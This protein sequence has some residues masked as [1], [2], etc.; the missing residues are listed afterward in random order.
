MTPEQ[1]VAEGITALQSPVVFE[2]VEEQPEYV[3]DLD[4]EVIAA[5]KKKGTL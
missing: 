1:A 2:L 5:M 3:G 4:E